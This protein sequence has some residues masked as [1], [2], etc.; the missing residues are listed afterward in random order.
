MVTDFEMGADVRRTRV[1]G[2]WMPRERAV[3]VAGNGESGK[4][5][6]CALAASIMAGPRLDLAEP[7]SFD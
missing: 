4:A 3:E 5:C 2:H 7:V 1:E 6:G